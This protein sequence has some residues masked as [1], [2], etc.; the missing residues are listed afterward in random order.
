MDGKTDHLWDTGNSYHSYRVFLV[1]RSATKPPFPHGALTKP[2]KTAV[3]PST[4]GTTHRGLRGPDTL[5]G[6]SECCSCGDRMGS[7]VDQDLEVVLD[8]CEWVAW[9]KVI[10]W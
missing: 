2:L 7:G 8:H 6:G 10:T 1:S 3:T 5:Q 4:R 9:Q